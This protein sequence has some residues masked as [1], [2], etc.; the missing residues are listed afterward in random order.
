MTSSWF[1]LST[2][3]YDARSTTHQIYIFRLYGAHQYATFPW[4]SQINAVDNFPANLLVVYFNI[5]FPYTP[6]YCNKRLR[7]TSKSYRVLDF[8]SAWYFTAMGMGL[9]TSTASKPAAFLVC[10]SGIFSYLLYN[11]NKPTSLQDISECPC[12]IPQCVWKMWTYLQE[13]GLSVV[14]SNLVN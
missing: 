10:F 11:H 14:N 9:R 4:F 3:N 1:S 5:I 12:S 13:Y 8:L 2:L 7:F 6:S